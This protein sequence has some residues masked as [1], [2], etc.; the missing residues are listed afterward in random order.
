MKHQRYSLPSRPTPVNYNHQQASGLPGLPDAFCQP[1]ARD[2]YGRLRNV[3][4]RWE[5]ND[6]TDIMFLACAGGYADVV[7]GE[8]Q[9]VGYLRQ[10]GDVPPGARLA[11]PLAETVEHVRVLRG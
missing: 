4:Q 7:A 9:A 3:G 6:L 8:R 11:T 5:K 2:L 10:A 1:R